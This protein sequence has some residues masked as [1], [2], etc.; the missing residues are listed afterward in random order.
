[1]VHGINGTIVRMMPWLQQPGQFQSLP[2][3]NVPP[4][5]LSYSPQFNGGFLN[6][7]IWSVSHR[8]REDEIKSAHAVVG[9]GMRFSGG[10]SKWKADILQAFSGTLT[11]EME[12]FKPGYAN[13]KGATLA[14]VRPCF[15][16]RLCFG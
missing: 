16:F 10:V 8:K 6:W 14:D 7:P 12:R 15:A 9:W 3:G 5:A 11:G 1:M 13:K 2:T 4:T